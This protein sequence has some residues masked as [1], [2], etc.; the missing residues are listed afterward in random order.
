MNRIAYLSEDI[1]SSFKKGKRY[2]KKGDRVT[3]ISESG[4]VV[5]VEPEQGVRFPLLK[6]QLITT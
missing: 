1:Y 4:H 5:I 6:T 3:V 2:G